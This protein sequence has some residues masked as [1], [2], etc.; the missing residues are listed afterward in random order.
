MNYGIC[1]AHIADNEPRQVC[2][3]IKA[4]S[5]KAAPACYCTGGETVRNAVGCTAA[6]NEVW[7][8]DKASFQKLTRGRKFEEFVDLSEEEGVPGSTPI[9][10]KGSKENSGSL[11]LSGFHDYH[12]EC[13]MELL[14]ESVD[15]E[16]SAPKIS[17]KIFESLDAYVSNCKIHIQ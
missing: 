10:E 3:A 5:I 15:F 9:S 11:S 16:K 7:S 13:L 1:I 12:F 17:S 14:V 8:M 6:K 4:G 2:G